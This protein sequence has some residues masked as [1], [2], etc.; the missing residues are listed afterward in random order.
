MTEIFPE[1]RKC[2][3][4]QSIALDS[5]LNY[6]SENRKTRSKLL[7]ESRS[8][9]Q[10][11]PQLATLFLLDW[12]SISFSSRFFF[13]RRSWLTAK[14]RKTIQVR[15]LATTKLGQRNRGQLVGKNN[16]QY[17]LQCNWLLSEMEPVLFASATVLTFDTQ[18]QRAGQNRVELNSRAQQDKLQCGRKSQTQ[19]NSRRVW[20][21]KIGNL[22]LSLGKLRLNWLFIK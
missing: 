2:N 3:Q 12:L 20:P 8:C 17:K 5:E 4:L 21:A 16:M 15:K 10:F 11:W 22:W 19:W 7:T 18:P 9:Q 6:G 13:A 14:S 1:S